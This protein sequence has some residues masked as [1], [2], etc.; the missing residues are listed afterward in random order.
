[1]TKLALIFALP[2]IGG[3]AHLSVKEGKY[4]D[5]RTVYEA[6]C[7]GGHLSFTDCMRVAAETCNGP[8]EIKEGEESKTEIQGSKTATV[9]HT[10]W[11]THVSM[12]TTET[13]T[14]KGMMFRCKKEETLPE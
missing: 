1:M 3:C 5:G 11:V 13:R 9:I 12:D 10:R 14:R 8:Y 6:T 7:Y 4:P 2:L